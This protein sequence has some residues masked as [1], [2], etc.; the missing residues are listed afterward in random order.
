GR[1]R[2]L[3]GWGKGQVPNLGG[4]LRPPSV[5]FLNDQQASIAQR[6]REGLRIER[7]SLRLFPQKRLDGRWDASHTQALRRELRA[8]RCCKWCECEMVGVRCCNHLSSL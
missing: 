1:H 7:M 5:P 2:T 8:L 3:D 6:S 4:R